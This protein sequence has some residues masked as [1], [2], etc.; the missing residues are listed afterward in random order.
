MSMSFKKSDWKR[1]S[2]LAISQG[3]VTMSE[4]TLFVKSHCSKS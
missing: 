4:F 1:L 3:I 2:D